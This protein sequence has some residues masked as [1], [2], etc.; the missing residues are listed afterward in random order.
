MK[1]VPLFKVCAENNI[2]NVC[3]GQTCFEVASIVYEEKKEWFIKGEYQIEGDTLKCQRLEKDIKITIN[4]PMVN[5]VQL[6]EEKELI[7]EM[8][9]EVFTV[10]VFHRRTLDFAGKEMKR[11]HIP[12]FVE[13]VFKSHYKRTGERGD[14][15]NFGVVRIDWEN[16]KVFIEKV[17]E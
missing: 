16:K 1:I 11:A 15:K 2:K 12:A 17:S 13:A 3:V 5:G 8:S 7:Q 9:D 10:A 4:R 6:P 14:P